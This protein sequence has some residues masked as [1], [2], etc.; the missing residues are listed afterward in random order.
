MTKRS[1]FAF[2]QFVCFCAL[3]YVGGYW[4]FVRLSVE[5]RALQH[6]MVDPP[7]MPPLWKINISPTLDYVLNGLIFAATLLVLILIV[8]AIR[9]RVRSNAIWTIGAFVLAFALSLIVHSGFVPL[10]PGN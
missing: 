6:G 9:K 8:Q 5:L 10:T 4:A 2:L 7:P 3:F 1:V